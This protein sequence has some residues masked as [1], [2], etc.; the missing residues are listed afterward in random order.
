[1]NRASSKTKKKEE[2]WCY[3]KQLE[4]VCE[5]IETREWANARRNVTRGK[6]DFSE[7]LMSIGFVKHNILPFIFISLIPL[8]TMQFVSFE[9]AN[10][11]EVI[12]CNS[13]SPYKI[14]D[15]GVCE[16][17]CVCLPSLKKHLIVIS[18]WLQISHSNKKWSCS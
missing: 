8:L 5:L 6:H 11:T 4:Y 13:R 15:V 3:S 7:N 10:M 16:C 14:I 9:L 2:I 1:M 12:N 17:V 18:W